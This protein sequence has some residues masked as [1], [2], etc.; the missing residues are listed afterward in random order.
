VFGS[1]LF[2]RA[3]IALGNGKTLVIEAKGN[4]PNRP[5]VRSVTWDGKPYTRSWFSHAQILQ[6]GTIVFEMGEQPNEKFG[7]AA[8]DR[9]P[10][11]A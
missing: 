5:Y 4:A 3:T 9:P 6:G 10:S 2:D 1:P 7:A 11:F 8:A